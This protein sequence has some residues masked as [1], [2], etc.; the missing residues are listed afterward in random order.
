M[1]MS[2]K[3]MTPQDGRTFKRGTSFVFFFALLL[4]LIIIFLLLALL[5][6]PLSVLASRPE[7]VHAHLGVPFSDLATAL[8]VLI[9]CVI[10]VTI[11]QRRSVWR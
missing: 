2:L 6:L 11:A 1:F 10:A 9:A 7:V 4:L 8:G 3:Q 5:L